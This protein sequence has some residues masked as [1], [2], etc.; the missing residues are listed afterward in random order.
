[1]LCTVQLRP[2]GNEELPSSHRQRCAFRLHCMHGWL[3]TELAQAFLMG[4][5]LLS[6]AC[7][8][9]AIVPVWLLQ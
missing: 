4:A 3:R 8:G 1:M 5:P 9:M 2:D 6:N 7:V